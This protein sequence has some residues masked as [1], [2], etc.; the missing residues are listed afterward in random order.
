MTSHKVLM[1][2]NEPI[3]LVTVFNVFLCRHSDRKIDED[4]R[5]FYPGFCLN[6]VSAQSSSDRV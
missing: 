4:N 1:T 2:M 3:L 5:Q 6:K